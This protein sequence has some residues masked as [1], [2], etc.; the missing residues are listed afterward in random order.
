MSIEI[1]IVAFGSESYLVDWFAQARKID[2]SL[3]IADNHPTGSTI[4]ACQQHDA[5][6][7]VVVRTLALPHN[8]GFG[9]ACNALAASSSADW[10]VFLNPDATIVTFPENMLQLGSVFGAYQRKPDG[11]AVHCSGQSYRVRDE[12][13]R[14]WL[15]RMP[16]PANGRGYVSG[17][18]MAIARSEFLALGGF[19]ERMFLF[20]ED[21][22][23]CI[24]AGRSGKRVLLHPEW[25]VI[26]EVGH[27]TRRDWTTALTTSYE[28]GRYFHTKHRHCVRGFDAYVAADSLARSLCS[29]LLRNRPK[30]AAYLGLARQALRNLFRCCRPGEV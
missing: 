13:S 18:A 23:L 15:R 3:A 14:G 21:I 5:D 1:C 19:D 4:A 17:G 16:H 28:S 26:H 27:A 8:P 25:R 7:G 10:L 20:Y 24:R 11:Q 6:E 12:I 2:A 9:A 29:T 22:D 30:R